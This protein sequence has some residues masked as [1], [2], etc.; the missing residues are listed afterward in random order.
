MGNYRV[1]FAE[2]A[3]G[4]SLWGMPLVLINMGG[5][6]IYILDQRLHAQSVANDKSHKVLDDVVRSML[7][8][9]LVEQLFKPQELYTPASM[10]QVFDRLAHSSIMRLSV[11]SMDKL[12]DL[13]TMGFKHQIVCAA[14]PQEILY[15]TYNHID[16][17]RA[18]CHAEDVIALVDTTIQ[19]LNQTY[20]GFTTGDFCELRHSMCN[21]FQDKHVKVSLFLQQQIQVNEGVFR[22]SPGGPTPPG[23]QTTPVG[24]IRYF[25]ALGEQAHE[26]TVAVAASEV[27]CAPL[28]HSLYPMEARQCTLGT[29]MYLPDKAPGAPP[30]AQSPVQPAAA[31]PANTSAAPAASVTTEASAMAEL[32]LLA[33]LMGEAVDCCEP[34]PAFKL[35]LFG[36]DYD[37]VAESVAGEVQSRKVESGGADNKELGN[38]M[39]DFDSSAADAGN[40][41]DDLLSL[42][43]NL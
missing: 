14:H 29:N 31:P 34:I 3:E 25:D 19:R 21:F 18:L 40:D 24:T 23:S 32:N 15:A 33:T 6:M 2:V 27:A 12:Y 26:G 13:M 36:N 28:E 39:S 7:N 35:N 38:I 5:E 4:M 16:S 42:M 1:E 20:G 9:K 11:A 8:S 41:D 22:I 30:P 10:R 37:G 43:D 17:I